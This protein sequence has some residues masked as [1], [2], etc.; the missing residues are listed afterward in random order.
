M[1]YKGVN[2]AASPPK[3]GPAEAGGLSASSLPFS[4][5]RPSR[6]LVSTL[7]SLSAKHSR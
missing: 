6:N 1:L 3:D 4:I 5:D 2:N 7:K